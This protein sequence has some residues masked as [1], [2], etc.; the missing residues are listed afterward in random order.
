MLRGTVES[1]KNRCSGVLVFVAAV[2]SAWVFVSLAHALDVPP[3]TGRVVDLAHVLPASAVESVS[4]R[5]A[6]HE[7][8]TGN[9]AAVL[10]VPSLEGDA[11]EEFSH[12]VAT[13]WKL[14]QKGT[15]NGV[16]LV[17]AIQERKVRIEVGYGLEGALTDARSARIIRNDIV[18]RFRAGDFAGGVAAGIDA[19]VRTIE[20]T[21]QAS[22]KP[23]PR[24]DPD[25]LGQIMIAIMVGLMLGFILMNVNRLLG[26]I[27][28]T[29][30]SFLLAPWLVPA[31]IAGGITLMLLLFLSS[32]GISGRRNMRSGMD[33][34]MWYRSR[35]GGWG[36]GTFG[37]VGG[38]FSGG[39]GSFGG[40]GASGNW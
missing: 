11:L 4:A 10:I 39:G 9:Q 3:L 34:W 21:Y 37:G 7:A 17:V 15:D 13:T 29:G 2:T 5:L 16:L 36:G 18:P 26:P 1:R 31:L 40:G 33:N 27:A 28:G 24:Q 30:L 20:G 32:A 22:E 8:A 19:I 14:G 6:S 12:R 25:L 38:G 35:G 23:V